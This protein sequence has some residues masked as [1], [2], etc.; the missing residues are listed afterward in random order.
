MNTFDDNESDKENE[1]F[2]QDPSTRI[3]HLASTSPYTSVQKLDFG[4][5][6]S[7]KPVRARPFHPTPV[8]LRTDHPGDSERQGAVNEPEL[9]LDL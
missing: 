7:S 3:I 6:A 5:K 2:S 9:T 8:K 4:V 1:L